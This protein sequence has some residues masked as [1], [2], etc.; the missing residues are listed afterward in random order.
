MLWR[1]PPHIAAAG[2]NVAITNGASA[3]VAIPNRSDGTRARWV[4]ISIEDPSGT[5][6]LQ[7]GNSGVTASTTTSPC[8]T[9][10]QGPI[11]LDVTG[12]THIAA[13]LVTVASSNLKVTPLENQ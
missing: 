1:R 6:Y 3:S 2:A 10:N 11:V 5:F 8:F 13:R 4:L 9:M 7:P 12:H